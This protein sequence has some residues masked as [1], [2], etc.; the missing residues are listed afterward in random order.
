MKRWKTNRRKKAPRPE[1]KVPRI[2]INLR[3]LVLPPAAVVALA[4]VFSIAQAALSLPVRQLELE[5]VFQRVTPLQ[6]EAAVVETLDRGFLALDLERVQRRLEALDWIDAAEVTR[7]WPDTLV[8]RVVEQQ[9]AARWG[10]TGLLNTRGELFSNDPRYSLPE[11][12]VLSGPDG[13]EH[14]VAERYLHLRERLKRA[15]LE[16]RGLTMDGRGAWQLELDA[17]QQIRLGKDRVTERLD[18][19]FGVVLPALAAELRRVNYIDLRYTNGFAIAW[20]GEL[21][22]SFAN[23]SEVAGSG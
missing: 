7:I 3:W 22:L 18:R 15:N 14:E 20:L 5:G 23:S 12:P 1:L 19:L 4:A 6:I 16:L 13:S 9:A 8:I 21:E 17:G 11:L 2:R 10:D